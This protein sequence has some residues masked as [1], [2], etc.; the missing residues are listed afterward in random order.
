METATLT[1][2]EEA[3]VERGAA[4]FS[5]PTMEERFNGWAQRVASQGKQEKKEREERYDPPDISMKGRSDE[6]KAFFEAV[7]ERE[8]SSKEPEK[9][10]A[11]RTEERSDTKESNPDSKVGE[12]SASES[13]NSPSEPLSGDRHWQ[14]DHVP[15]EKELNDF[16]SRVE[17]RAQVALDYINQHAEREKIVQGLRGM[18]ADKGREFEGD[19]HKCLSECV[20]PGEV[21]RHLALMPSDREALRNV[22]DSKAMRAAIRTIST[23]YS[24][25]A[26]Q[27]S[28]KPRAPKPPSEVG[29]RGAAGDDGGETD[30]ANL[31]ARM[32]QRY[33]HAR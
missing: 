13:T 17:S 29:G 3:Q 20:N 4:S 12:K 14:N 8:E 31:S 30:F 7:G 2:N 15:S 23:H 19:L 6:E 26:P 1:K 10:A 16:R 24:A 27:A 9:D 11:K 33:M 5:E 18:T 25:S 32:N 22:K 28:P 21:L